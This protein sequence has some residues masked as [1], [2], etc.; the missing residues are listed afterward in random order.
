LRKVVAML[1][2]MIEQVKISG[3]VSFIYRGNELK[4]W[5]HAGGCPLSADCSSAEAR[6]MLERAG[7]R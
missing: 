4:A 5:K 6:E 3:G 1:R 2:V 7:K